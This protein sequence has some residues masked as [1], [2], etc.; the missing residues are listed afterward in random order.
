M[1]TNK[2]D[3]Y[4]IIS[5]LMA[6]VMTACVGQPQV[7]VKQTSTAEVLS[8]PLKLLQ[9][10]DT[11]MLVGGCFGCHGP[12]GQSQASAIPSLAG[13]P[14]DYFVHV[15]LAYQYGGRYS[16][17]M[18]RIALGFN[19]DEIRRMAG[20]FSQQ[21][22]KPQ[23]QRVSWRRVSQGRQLHRRYCR[24]CHGDA[25]VTPSEGAP[26]LN[27]HWM[28]YLRWTLKDYL[29]GINQTQA[30]MSQGLADLVKRHGPEGVEALVHYYAS[31]RP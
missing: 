23:Y 19:E 9:G 7:V 11:G 4:L 8:V 12:K 29:V 24:K 15:M 2:A 13:L 25:E 28:S 21:A 22:L 14:E 27:S 3:C 30:G 6:L 18:G 1:Y 26:R 20:Y 5:L 17:V 31:N 16:S 10:A